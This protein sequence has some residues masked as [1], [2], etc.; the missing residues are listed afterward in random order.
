MGTY[1]VFFGPRV[2]GPVEPL[3]CPIVALTSFFSA[4]KVSESFKELDPGCNTR[5]K[6]P[7]S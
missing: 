7:M 5:T 3:S 2:I 1:P 6:I 4:C